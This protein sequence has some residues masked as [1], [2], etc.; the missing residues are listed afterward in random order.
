MANIDHKK[1]I[2]GRI[3]KTKERIKKFRSEL[4]EQMKTAIMAAFGLLIALVWKDVI[5]SFV[6]SISQRAP[7]QGQLISAFLVTI[8]CVIGIM[9]ITKILTPKEELDKKPAVN[10]K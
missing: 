10:G 1:I 6:D 2:T 3:E 7:V 5:T 8:I 4:R 9:I